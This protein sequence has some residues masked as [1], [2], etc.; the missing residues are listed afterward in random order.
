MASLTFLRM[1]VVLL[2]AVACS[3]HYMIIFAGLANDKSDIRYYMLTLMMSI[4]KAM[5]VYIEFQHYY[6]LF[7]LYKVALTVVYCLLSFVF[8]CVCEA[9]IFT[10][11][12]E[13]WIAFVYAAGLLTVDALLSIGQFAYGPHDIIYKKRPSVSVALNYSGPSMKKGFGI[14]ARH[15]SMTSDHKLD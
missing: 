12:E 13:M 5:T 11:N 10:F 14:A 9:G 2:A 7:L 8:V 15:V 3:V 6:E 1:W 4:L